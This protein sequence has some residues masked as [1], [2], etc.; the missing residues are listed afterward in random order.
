MIELEKYLTIYYI[1]AF[2]LTKVFPS[3]QPIPAVN[4]FPFLSIIPYF[5]MQP[6]RQLKTLHQLLPM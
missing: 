2:A 5:V 4:N 3:C 1:H 6:Q